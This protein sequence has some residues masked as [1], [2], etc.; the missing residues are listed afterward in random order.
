MNANEYLDTLESVLPEIAARAGEAEELRRI[1]AETIRTLRERG[2][3]KELQ[4]ARYGGF[5]LDP[6]TFYRAAGRIGEACGST[7]WVFGILGVHPWQLG[8]FPDGTTPIAVTGHITKHRPATPSTMKN[9]KKRR[10]Y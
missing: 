1:P 7:A 5:E 4:P 8:L 9:T 10:F 2:L 3:M 6:L